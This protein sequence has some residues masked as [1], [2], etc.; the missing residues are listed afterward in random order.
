[1]HVHDD[2]V[3]R[4]VTLTLDDV[5]QALRIQQVFEAGHLL[6]QLTHQPVVGVL[7][8][9][10]VTADLFSTIG[11]PVATINHSKHN[12]TAQQRHVAFT[13]RRRCLLT[14]VAAAGVAHIL[15]W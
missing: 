9:H 3:L 12:L 14:E 4:S 2:C 5:S 7:I 1:M 11:I 10:G 6:L 8:D 15:H 13:R